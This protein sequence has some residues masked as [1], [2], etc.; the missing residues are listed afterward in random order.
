[1]AKKPREAFPQP[2][3]F[4]VQ[5]PT[6]SLLLGQD[7]DVTVYLAYTAK[8]YSQTGHLISGAN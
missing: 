4:L 6:S 8:M 2:A 7:H 1:M 3:F 5:S